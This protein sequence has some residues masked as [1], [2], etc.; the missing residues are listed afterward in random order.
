M[1]EK[2]V[3][4]LSGDA[5]SRSVLPAALQSESPGLAVETFARISEALTRLAGPE[6]DAAVCCIDTPEELAYLIRLRK[7]KPELPIILLTRVTEPGFDA[8]AESMGASVVVRKTAGLAATSKSIALA[9]ETR[10]LVRE[11]R[12]FL[13]RS[14]ELSQDLKRLARTNR[15]LIQQALGV[16]ASD[17]RLFL[18]L[19]VEDDP[20]QALLL[21][22]AMARA[23]LPPF[24][25]SV[26]STEEAIA[27]LEGKG[28]Y[29]D[30][31]AFPLPALV[32]TDL[33]LP[34]KSGLDLLDWMRARA[35]T[36]LIGVIMLTS[37][38]EESD[39]EEAYKRGANLYLVKRLDTKEA[40]GV[41]REIYARFR[42]EREN[43]GT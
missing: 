17:Q 43:P 34:R 21:I 5:K 30:R 12:V 13:H 40:I 15:N 10:A 26:G 20:V 8:L 33:T 16:L 32:V 18:T 27:Y 6:F 2:K 22:R 41:V 36:R 39:M 24:L 29:A 31:D 25:R 1:S 3:L 11:S 7:R 4:L 9:L 37:S 38:E 42:I 23:K 19:I 35:E 14:K 28:Q